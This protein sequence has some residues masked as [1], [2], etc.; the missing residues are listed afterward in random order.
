[1]K[2]EIL[3]EN[4]EIFRKGRKQSEKLGGIFKER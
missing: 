4:I 3:T 2:D 1:M